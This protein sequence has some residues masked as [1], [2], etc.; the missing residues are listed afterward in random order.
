MPRLHQEDIENRGVWVAQLVKRLTV[1]FS[2]SHDLM[3][4]EIEPCVRLCAH[5]VEPD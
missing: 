3:V 2:S 4:C 5:S 1:D